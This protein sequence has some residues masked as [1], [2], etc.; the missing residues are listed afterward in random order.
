MI[1]PWNK[2]GTPFRVFPAVKGIKFR[3]YSVQV[4]VGIPATSTIKISVHGDD[5]DDD[6]DGDDDDDDD[7]HHAASWLVEVVTYLGT[8]TVPVNIH[9]M[10]A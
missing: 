7:E 2:R 3:C 1:S 10:T 8:K 6:D 4:V 5:V 9:Q